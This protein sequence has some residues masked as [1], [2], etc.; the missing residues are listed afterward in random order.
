MTQVLEKR[1]EPNSSCPL[2]DGLGLNHCFLAAQA[3]GMDFGLEQR[4]DRVT[5]WARMEADVLPGAAA[6]GGAAPG[7]PPAPP[8]PKGLQVYCIDDSRPMRRWLGHSLR[9][10]GQVHTYGADEG[11]L[12]AFVPAALRQA[13]IVVCDQNLDF[14]GRI[15]YGTDLVERLLRGGFRGLLC[16]HSANDSPEDIA[17][18]K[19]SGA[20][21]CISKG[22]R[23]G[24]IL[25]I[26]KDAYLQLPAARQSA[27]DT[28]PAPSSQVSQTLC[29]TCSDDGSP[30]GGMSQPLS[31]VSLLSSPQRRDGQP[32]G[33]RPARADAKLHPLCS[34]GDLSEQPMHER[35]AIY[36]PGSSTATVE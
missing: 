31:L 28:S 21:V 23:I 4:G 32:G 19:A 17:K 5:F 13:D 11:D 27:S 20:H 2:S 18:Y 7:A 25:D 22:M 24:Q 33:D 9:P 29:E 34:Y 26:L 16:I 1:T 35:A 30:S 3:L 15:F 12:L 10:C 14:D 8:F 6:G 36:L